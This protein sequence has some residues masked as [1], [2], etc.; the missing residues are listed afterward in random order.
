[1]ELCRYENF[2]NTK[3][4]PFDFWAKHK[5]DLEGLFELAVTVLSTPPTIA[6]VERMFS[7]ALSDEN[8]ENEVMLTINLKYIQNY[9]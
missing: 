1:M 5:Q 6:P 9:I 8:L 3:L 7:Q 2:I 4:E